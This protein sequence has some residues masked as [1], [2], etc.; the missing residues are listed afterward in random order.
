MLDDLALIAVRIAASLAVG[1]AIG[2]ERGFH[3]RPAG[4]RTRALV[5]P[6]RERQVLYARHEPRRPQSLYSD[7]LIKNQ[8]TG[9]LSPAAESSPG[10]G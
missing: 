6:A 9:E 3:S 10:D 8:L 4:F 1:A 2:F 7:G 5:Y